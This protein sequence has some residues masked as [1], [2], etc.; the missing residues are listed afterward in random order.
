M[1]LAERLR[2]ADYFFDIVDGCI[3]KTKKVLVDFQFVNAIY[4]KAA[5]KNQIDRLADFSGIAVLDGKY[6][7][8]MF[9]VND[10][11]ISCLKISAGDADAFRKN[12]LGS[13]VCEST[14]QSNY[15]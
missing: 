3:G 4:E 5:R 2:V 8:V 11:I 12:P 13:N 6:S 15:V 7:N 9:S 14:F 10:R 1:T